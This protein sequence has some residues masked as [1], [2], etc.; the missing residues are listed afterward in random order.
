MLQIDKGCPW[1][2]CSFCGMYKGM[3]HRA[4]A[5]DE[6]AVLIRQEARY[7][8][9]ATRVFL[10]DGD[11]MRQ[12]F[13]ELH[14]ILLQLAQSLPRLTLVSL[15]ANGSSIRAQSPQEPDAPSVSREPNGNIASIFFGRNHP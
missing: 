5:L 4:R 3:A 12:P 10:V 1:N 9:D 7:H 6:I 13:R 15:Y 8:P 2:R 11:V 14:T